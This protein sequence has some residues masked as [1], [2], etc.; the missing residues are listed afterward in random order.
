MNEGPQWT[1]PLPGHDRFDYQPITR[2]PDW[3]WPYGSRLAVY[4]G[5]NLEHFAFGDGLGAALGP[6]SP[7]PDVLNYSWREYGNR[8]GAWRC[9]ELFGQLGL[10]AAAILNTA[11]YDHSP[12]LVAACVARGD[13]LV[14]HGHTNAE[15]QGGWSEPA[16]RG[17]L[18][19]CAGRIARESGQAPTGWL[20]PWISESAVTPDL[21][22]ETGYRYTLNWCHD[23]QP[24]AMRTRSGQRLWSVP[25]PQEL[26]D[27]PMI[28][29][30]QMDARDFF[31]L[32]LDNFDEMLAQSA[33]TP[34]VMGLALHPY[35]VG[36][37]Y[38]LRH[39][40]R[41]LQRLAQARDSGAIWFTTP[42]AIARHMDTLA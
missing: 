36:Q 28:M 31:D 11:L 17:L 2:R 40:R 16:E 29:A 21:L 41:A 30:R 19:S 38:R 23:D 3:R 27:I 8:V 1:G 37:P 6:P 13:E 10:P 18:A 25:Y 33:A 7:Q 34:L 5:F 26:N 14:G 12:E 22:A 4:L 24:V 15:R 35:I 32:V 9:L 39:L 42:G 20:S